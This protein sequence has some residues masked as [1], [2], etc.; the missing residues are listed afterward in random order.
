MWWRFK[1]P[2]CRHR[3]IKKGS[4]I[5]AMSLQKLKGYLRYPSVDTVKLGKTQKYGQ[6][7]CKNCEKIHF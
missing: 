4:K 1:I 2:L 6:C 5:W 7:P 3:K